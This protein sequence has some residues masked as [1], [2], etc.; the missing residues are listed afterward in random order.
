MPDKGSEKCSPRLLKPGEQ[1]GSD[2]QITNKNEMHFLGRYLL[3]AGLPPGSPMVGG[4]N[5]KYS[6]DSRS[7]QFG[8]SEIDHR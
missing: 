8:S 2:L 7:H 4:I 5:G 3:F 6:Y 1:A